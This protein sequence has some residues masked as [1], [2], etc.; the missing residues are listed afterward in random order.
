MTEN[1]PEENNGMPNM[2]IISI[3]IGVLILIFLLY[4]VLYGQNNF[5]TS[6]GEPAYNLANAFDIVK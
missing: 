4:N 5:S 6:F 3:V 1:N 2:F